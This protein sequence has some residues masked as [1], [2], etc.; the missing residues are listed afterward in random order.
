MRKQGGG[1][2]I[3]T[4]VSAMADVDV[5]V[6]LPP[7]VVL[8]SDEELTIWHQFSRAR[9]RG[10][11]RDVDLI[12]LAKAVRLESDIR[13]YQTMLDE[14][15][16]LLKNDRGTMVVNPLLSAIDTLQRQQLSIFRSMSLNNAPADARTLTAA[17]KTAQTAEKIVKS[18]PDDG[19]LATPTHH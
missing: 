7:G 16:I 9:A 14:A 19:L 5:L 8:R 4:L 2:S 15:G 10:D 13:Q 6:D 18:L 12:L 11:W 1:K 17:A 3:E